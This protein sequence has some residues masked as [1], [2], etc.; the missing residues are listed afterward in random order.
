MKT[1]IKFLVS[2]FLKSFIY[3]V[4]TIF[5][6]IVIINLL[7]E[8][9]FFREIDVNVFFTIYL[10]LLNSPSMIFEVFPFIFLL[11][12][13]VFFIKL[14]TN[15][16]IQIFKYSGLKNSRI[17]LITSSISLILGLFIISVFYNTS[18]NLKNFY[19]E[20]KSVYTKDGKYLAVINKNGLWIRDK[21]ED[22]VLII[23]SSKIEGN[24]LINNFITEFD[25]DFEVIRNIKSDTIDIKKN[26]WKIINPEI[27]IANASKKENFIEINSNFN[28]ERIQS[29]FSNLSSLSFLGLLELK[30]NYKLLNFSTIDIDIHIQKLIS[31]PIYLILMTVFSS[32]LMF[33]SKKIKSNT[34]K[35]SIGLFLCVLIYYLNNLFYVL[36]LTER[37]HYMIS[38]W[39]PLFVLIFPIL[40]MTYRVNE[41]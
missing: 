38:V 40:I 17:L 35:I 8:L 26:K 37:L 3:V 24:F 5:S 20:L 19:L 28:Y 29:L 13:Q 34:L 21:I 9:E 32:V 7:T 31:Y 12:T 10:A 11:T 18:S 4:C 6:L 25:R 36:G 1:Y 23:N 16:E 41:K 30:R 22:K 33:G 2:T 15:N 14:F 39:A 27:F